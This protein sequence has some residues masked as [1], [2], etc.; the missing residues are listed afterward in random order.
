MKEFKDSFKNN[1]Y[2][3]KEFTNFCNNITNLKNKNPSIHS[4]TKKER[5]NM[6]KNNITFMAVLEE[7]NKDNPSLIEYP[8]LFKNDYKTIYNNFHRTFRKKINR[9]DKHNYKTKIVRKANLDEVYNL[10]EQQIKRLGGFQFPKHFFEEYLKLKSSLL[11]L[12]YNKKE[13]I[14]FSFCFENKE[15]L[16][17][18][19]GSAKKEYLNK[20]VGYKLY[21][22][23]IKYACKNKLNLHMGLGMYKTGFSQIKKEA[24]AIN[25]KCLR[26]PN[27]E[28]MIKLL[29]PLRKILAPLMRLASKLFPRKITHELI[30]FT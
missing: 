18:S 21:H 27:D 30:P 3:S 13:L 14:A 9:A 8:I 20:N 7:T 29:Y 15:N 5:K 28:K 25:F 10:Y 6:E 24:G 11:F 19:L 23:R 2:L 12:I 26:H 22:E 1:Y 17:M 16:Y 4:Y